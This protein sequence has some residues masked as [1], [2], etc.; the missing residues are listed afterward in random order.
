MG[1]M[2]ALSISQREKDRSFFSGAAARET[3]ID[4]CFGAFVHQISGPTSPFRG[5]GRCIGNSARRVHEPPSSDSE[6]FY[7]NQLSIRSPYPD[8]V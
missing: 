1:F 2:A 6:C 5:G 8:H 4:V 3:T 7:A